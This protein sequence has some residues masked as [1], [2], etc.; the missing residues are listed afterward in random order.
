MITHLS[1]SGT[2]LS[3]YKKEM[4]EWNKEEFKQ[5][6]VGFIDAEGNFQVFYGCSASK[7][8][9]VIFRIRLHVDDI[10]IL[11][12]IKELLGVGKVFIE[13]DSA[14][15]VITNAGDLINVRASRPILDQYKLLTTKYLDYLDFVKVVN[16]L[17]TNKSSVFIGEDLTW[18]APADNCIKNM[19]SGRDVIDYSLI[20]NTPVTRLRGFIEG[21]K[22]RSFF[23]TF[24][25]KNLV[26]YFQIGQ[27]AKNTY[28]LVAISRFT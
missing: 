3:L 14:L 21:V 18:L 9:R 11:Y 26:P 7:Y 19:N 10:A 15:F 1:V 8:I 4:K 25:F 5:W 23:S 17:I 20:P 27:H 28:V 22:K 24:G 6:L 16:K 13:K 12:R 2:V